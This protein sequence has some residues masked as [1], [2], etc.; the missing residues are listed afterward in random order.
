MDQLPWY[1]SSLRLSFGNAGFSASPAEGE[2]ERA[3]AAREPKGVG[4]QELHSFLVFVFFV[5]LFGAKQE[6]PVLLFGTKCL[7]CSEG[8]KKE[9]CTF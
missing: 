7:F 6:G 4:P 2:S 9:P 1:F 5:L 3:G 8:C